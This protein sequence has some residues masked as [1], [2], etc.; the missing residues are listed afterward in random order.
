MST[1][2][3]GYKILDERYALLD[4]LAVSSMGE[5]YRGRDLELAQTE[6]AP[7][8]V[9]I[10]ILP[11]HYKLPSLAASTQQ[12]QQL[13]K[14]L[15]KAWLL[16]ILAHGDLG[17]RQY[18]VLQ[19]PEGLGAHS[20]MS[21][22]SQQLPTLSKLMQQ[23]GSLV[24][25]KQLPEIIDSALLISLPNQQLYLLAT[26]LIQPLQTLGTHATGLSLYKR[27][28]L[29]LALALSSIMVIAVSTFAI[30]YRN[31]TKATV[32]IQAENANLAFPQRLLDQTKTTVK[33]RPAQTELLALPLS[34]QEPLPKIEANL[35][36]LSAAEPIEHQAHTQ[37]QIDTNHEAASQLELAE[38]ATTAENSEK[39]LVIAAKTSF[40]KSANPPQAPIKTKGIDK[41]TTAVTPSR[42]ASHAVPIPKPDTSE[43]VYYTA[44]IETIPVAAPP[45]KSVTAA[46]ELSIEDLI[47]R[48]NRALDL[49]NFS[50]K[51]G[52]LFYARQIKIRDHLHPQIERL[53]RFVVMY[54][55]EIARNS[56]KTNELV[57]AQQLLINSKNLIQE[58]NLKSLNAA[59]QVLEHKSNQYQSTPSNH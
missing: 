35:V 27:P 50:T 32:T 29:K 40:K 7:S 10:H 20:V 2:G 37:T 33:D 51:N 36:K 59:Q 57:Q 4:C 9:L 22:P 30:E 14:T 3:R 19:S 38:A 1:S 16:A 45:K 18:F 28:T 58:F 44:S 5:V 43:A 15:D 56:L 54:Q 24:K 26:A 31:H 21:L 48:A 34:L 39:N 46:L 47:E 23:F 53:G 11:S 42:S 13:T 55:H 41:A 12:I 52:V 49:K 25:N 6:H 8:R 17:D